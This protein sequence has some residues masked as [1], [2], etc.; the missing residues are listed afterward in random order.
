[1]Q[2]LTV[3]DSSR[4]SLPHWKDVASCIPEDFRYDGASSP[5]RIIYPLIYWSPY[6]LAD[7]YIASRIHDFGYGPARLIGSPHV[8][9]GDEMHS[10]STLNRHQWD[11]IYR[12]ALLGLHHPRIAAIHH[13]GLDLLGWL[14][15]QRNDEKFAKRGI[16]TYDNWLASR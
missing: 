16:I 3:S 8:A 2:R 13:G 5:F 11:E 14:A 4:C 15:W 9:M 12:L 10:L 6:T 1:M 7:I